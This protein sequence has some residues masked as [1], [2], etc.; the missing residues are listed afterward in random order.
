MNYLLQLLFLLLPLLLFSETT[1]ISL[2]DIRRARPIQV[3]IWNEKTPIA[4]KKPLIIFS[5]GSRGDPSDQKWLF[6]RLVKEGFI[7]VSVEHFGNCRKNCHPV[8]FMRAWDRPLDIKMVLDHLLLNG[9]TSRLIDQN[10]IAFCGYSLGGMTGIW[11]AGGRLMDL[12]EAAKLFPTKELPKSLI[13]KLLPRI[14]VHES[15]GSYRDNRIKAVVALAPAAWGFTP[16]SLEMIDTPILII[17]PKEDEVLPYSFHA[18]YLSKHIAKVDLNPIEGKGGHQVFLIEEGDS[19]RNG[20]H[21]KT[22]QLALKFLRKH[23]QI[24]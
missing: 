8:F 14:N 21:E 18:E 9:E 4:S 23:L 6:D 17:A 10:K 19:Y 11:I 5:H 24:Q 16:E 15:R 20:V 7:V 3:E 1:K 22:L 13:E 12:N 2:F